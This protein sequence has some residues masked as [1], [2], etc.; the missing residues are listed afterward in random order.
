M[1]AW[2][3]MLTEA[4]GVVHATFAHPG[5]YT[6]PGGAP[7]DV[8]VRFYHEV[9]R[10]GDLDREGYSRVLSDET[11]LVLLQTE[12][13]DPPAD[14]AVVDLGAW[15]AWRLSHREPSHNP[16][17]WHVHAIRIRS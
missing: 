5:T 4:L 11:M 17:E 3:D 8:S 6:A 1:T 14:N 2:A 12:L 7:V 16:V 13:S 9:I 15:G 10:H